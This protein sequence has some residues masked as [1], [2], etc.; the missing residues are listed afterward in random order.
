[1]ES[2]GKQIKFYRLQ[3]GLSQLELS[4]RS[5]VSQASIAR[6]ESGK[7]KNLKRETMK[8]LAE[9]LD[10]SLTDLMEHPAG[11]KEERTPYALVRI[12]PVVK[13]K[14]IEKTININTLT[15]KAAKHEPSFSSDRNAFYLLISAELTSEPVID[16]GD[17]VLIEPYAA[18]KEGDMVLYISA[19]NLGIGKIYYHPD[20]FVIQPLGQNMPPLLFKKTKQKHIITILRICEIKKKG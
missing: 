18:I 4:Q 3:F 5:N 11:V 19:K 1:V 8:K 13:L 6:I 20:S 2:L 9:G 7:Q 14:D 15:K 17:M 16:E 12:I 10:I